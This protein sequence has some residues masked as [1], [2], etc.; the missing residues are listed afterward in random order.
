MDNALLAKFIAFVD[1]ENK[2]VKE[3]SKMLKKW[4]RKVKKYLLHHKLPRKQNIY[5]F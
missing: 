5:S 1:I 4:D 2:F 3:Q